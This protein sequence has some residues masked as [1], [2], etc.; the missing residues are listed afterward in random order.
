[1]NFLI[2]KI[3]NLTVKKFKIDFF[4]RFIHIHGNL[5]II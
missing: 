3:Q 5:N 4:Y 2:Y 1:M